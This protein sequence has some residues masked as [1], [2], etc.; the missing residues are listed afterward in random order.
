[1]AEKKKITV[2]VQGDYNTGKSTIML[3]I[4]NALNDAGFTNVTYRDPDLTSYFVAWQETRVKELK[5]ILEVD[6]EVE[7]IR[8]G[9]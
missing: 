8:R 3:V 5:D 7:Q 2:K 4:L 6:V 1:M 9:S